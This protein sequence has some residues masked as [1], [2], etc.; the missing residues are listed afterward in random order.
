MNIMKKLV[1]LTFSILCITGL[2][3]AQTM[4]MAMEAKDEPGELPEEAQ[5]F[6]NR[7]FPDEKV[8]DFEK[9]NKIFDSKETDFFDFDDQE[10]YE[11]ELSNGIKVEFGKEGTMT[12]MGSTEDIAIPL[13]ALPDLIEIYLKTNYMDEKVVAYEIDADDQEIELDNGIDLEFDNDGRFVEK[14]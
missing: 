13:H 1:L 12:E 4:E 9:F 10:A 7:H 8:V 14:D 11:V 3:Y 5:L 2:G 6:L